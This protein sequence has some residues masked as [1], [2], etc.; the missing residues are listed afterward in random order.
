M[1]PIL[2]EREYDAKNHQETLSGIKQAIL[3]CLKWYC[4]TRGLTEYACP[5][6]VEAAFFSFIDGEEETDVLR[7]KTTRRDSNRQ[8]IPPSELTA[9]LVEE[10]VI[11]TKVLYH[12]GRIEINDFAAAK[13]PTRWLVWDWRDKC[14]SGIVSDLD[15]YLVVAPQPKEEDQKVV[16]R[17]G[18]SWEELTPEEQDSV[19]RYADQ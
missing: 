1:P 2:R 10:L 13:E 12:L 15:K 17:F 8:S 11:A 6:K 19:R 3:R 18:R 14:T 16:R 7:L 4:Q 9:M 5:I